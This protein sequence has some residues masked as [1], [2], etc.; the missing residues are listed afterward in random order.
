MTTPPAEE[1][2]RRVAVRRL[3][4]KRDFRSHLFVYV[5]VNLAF[6]VGWA[7]DAAINGLA[8]PWPVF[9][10]VF[11]GLFVFGQARDV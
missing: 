11:W 2:L 8:F 3:K 4:K 5:V 7:V 6:W 1:E 9:P 10:T